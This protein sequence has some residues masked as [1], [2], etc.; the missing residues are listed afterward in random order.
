MNYIDFLN[1]KEEKFISSGFEINKKE[2]NENLFEYQKDVVK[3]ALK[4]GRAALF[5]ECGLG[6]TLQQLEWSQKVVNYTGG[7]VLILTP[8]AV[9]KQTVREG[10]KFGITVNLCRSEKDVKEGINITN[11][12]M[13]HA[14][15]L[16]EFTGV[17][18]DESSIL[19]NF[20]GKL[21]NE[22]IEGFKYTP[23]KL[24]C[25][26]TPSP[27]DFMEL[28]N[29]AEFLGVM[30]RTEMLSMFFVHDGGDTKSWR[31][32]GHAVDRF[33]KW[34]STWSVM[35][36]NPKDLGY[37]DNKFKLPGLNIH[38]VLVKTH[39]ETDKLIPDIAQT[40]NE[41]REARKN[42]L[43]E[44]LNKVKELVNGSNEQWL[45][46]C[47]YNYEGEA[48]KK[49]ITKSKEVKGS[50]TPEYKENSMLEF[51]DGGVSILITKP[52]IAG[53]G[54]NWQNCNNMIFFGL[55]DSYEQFYQSVRRCH[56]FGQQKEVNVY[57]ILGER[58]ISVL[59]NIK[60]KQEDAETMKEN[61]LKYAKNIKSEVKEEKKIKRS[62]A[63]IE[64]ELPVWI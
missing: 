12:E 23:Y 11:Y 54:M 24:A 60:R 55:S 46:W 25:T 50:D 26:A 9:A 59:N 5:E 43:E 31:L 62:I 57:V 18:L 38:E 17:V 56:R 34:V 40:L 47:D 7:K 49:E 21:R 22:I 64:M 35:I 3:W 28:G 27:N 53:F 30:T 1:T 14:F 45:I 44:R 15:N 29:H 36:T 20:T 6:K 51:A 58:E 32:K 42:S 61:M 4:K 2:L 8:L 39:E 63:N 52:K 13:L 41:R 19:K 16:E 48:L 10:L 37:F 33:W